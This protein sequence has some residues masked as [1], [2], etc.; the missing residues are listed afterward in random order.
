[1]RFARNRQGSKVHET[2]SLSWS[3]YVPGH[4]AAVSAAR[5]YPFGQ[6]T[7]CH[8]GSAELY[9]KNVFKTQSWLQR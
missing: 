1:M 4:Y 9:T 8:R 2:V 7:V 6:Y 3:A 5:D